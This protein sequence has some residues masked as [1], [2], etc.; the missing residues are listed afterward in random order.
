MT[1]VQ[2]GQYKEDKIN[3][4]LAL[5][6]VFLPVSDSW[7]GGGEMLLVNGEQEEGDERETISNTSLSSPPGIITL[8]LT[9]RLHLATVPW[10]DRSQRETREKRSKNIS[11][12]NLI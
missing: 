10:S 11:Q 9:R 12:P 4:F 3:F 1:F 6:I 8:A 7:V 5:C 2:T